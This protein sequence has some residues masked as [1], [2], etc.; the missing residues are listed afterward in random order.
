MGE[1]KIR[2]MIVDDHNVVRSGL[3]AFLMAFDD[4]EMVAEATSGLDAVEKCGEANPDV[5]L[6]DLIMPEMDGVES[7]KQIRQ[8]FSACASHRV[9]QF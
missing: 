5:I 8:R 4:L 1:E 9:N 2:V 3:S 6:M 7:T